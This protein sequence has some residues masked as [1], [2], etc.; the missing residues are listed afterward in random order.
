MRVLFI[1]DI[2]GSPGRQIVRERLADIVAQRQIDLV[3]AN[4]RPLQGFGITPRLAGS[5]G[6]GIETSSRR[7]P[8]LGRGNPRV[9]ATRTAA[10]AAGKL[11]KTSGRLFVGSQKRCEV[12]RRTRGA[13]LT[14]STIISQTRQRHPS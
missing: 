13:P 6:N 8:Q 3:I 14:P 5:Y 10:A 1:G 4:G 2:V 7:Q 9:H 12:R 11:R